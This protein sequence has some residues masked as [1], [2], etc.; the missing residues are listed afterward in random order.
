MFQRIRNIWQVTWRRCYDVAGTSCI[1]LTKMLQRI[2]NSRHVTW[3]RVFNVSGTSCKLLEEDV[4]TYQEHLVSYLKKMLRR[5]RHVLHVTWKKKWKR[6]R[7]VLQVTW[8]RCYNVSGTAGTLPEEEFSTY[9]ERLASYLKKMFQR[10]RN[11]WQVTWRRCYDVAGTS[12]MLLERGNDNVSGTSWKLLEE[13][14]TTYQER[15]ASD[16]AEMLEHIKNVLQVTWRRCHAVSGTSCKLLQEDVTTYQ[17]RLAS[18]LTKMSRRS[19]NVLPVC[20]QEHERYYPTPPH[21]TGNWSWKNSAV[22]V[23]A[24]QQERW[25]GCCACVCTGTWTLLPHP[26]PPHR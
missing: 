19:R 26:T 8:R 3:R 17:E 7:N 2:R 1:Y 25:W 10:I 13:D 11:I 15:L 6:I 4:P 24:G 14:V 12:C 16:L 23:S 5:S 18:H 20:A 22:P 9:Q 21:P